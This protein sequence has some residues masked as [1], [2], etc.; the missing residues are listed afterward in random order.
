MPNFLFVVYGKYSAGFAMKGTDF[1][2]RLVREARTPL[3]AFK[4]QS[5]LRRR[6]GEQAVKLY[7][8][9]GSEKTAAEIMDELKIPEETFAQILEFMNNNGMIRV[10]QEGEAL[11]DDQLPPEKDAEQESQ[12]EPQ[13][14]PSSLSPLEKIIYDKYGSIGVKVYHLIDGEKTAEEI[15]KQTG[16]SEAKLVEIL[17]FLDEKG[18]IKLESP[19][20]S[21]TATLGSESEEEQQPAYEPRFK[22]M[23]E[24]TPEEKPVEA[25][26]PQPKPPQLPKKEEKKE[27]PAED[28]VMIDVPQMTNL[29]FVQKAVMLAELSLKFPK[30]ARKLVSLVDGKKDFVELAIATGLSFFEI[31]S[32]F[33]YFGKK[34]FFTFRVLS[35]EEVKNRYGEDGFAI[36]KKYGRDGVLIYEMIGKESSLKEIITKSKLDVDRAIDIF[37]FIHQVLGLDIP[38]D[39]DLLYKQLGLKK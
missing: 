10:A 23:I 11:P 14:P 38:L 8:M 22:P 37:L 21:A 15:I 4:D 3:Q 13:L 6:F 24:E 30:E 1:D 28:I 34:G 25:P 35:R 16:I 36:Y 5:L 12:P 29:S 26:K 20:T 19:T 31:D 9:I 2:I 7:N 27:E 33:A 17:E 32:I 18:I 39:R